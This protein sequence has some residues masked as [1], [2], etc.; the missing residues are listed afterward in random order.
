MASVG[1]CVTAGQSAPTLEIATAMDAAP[2]IDVFHPNLPL[3]L[4]ASKRKTITYTAFLASLC[5]G[6]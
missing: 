1:A 4:N 3:V 6:F 2:V 5:P